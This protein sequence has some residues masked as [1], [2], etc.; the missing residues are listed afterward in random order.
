VS[1]LLSWPGWLEIHLTAW[2]DRHEMNSSDFTR[3]TVTESI[4]TVAY[5]KA[6][7]V[8]SITNIHIVLT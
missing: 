1:V 2:K 6:Y 5:W 3:D 7:N 4:D 8:S